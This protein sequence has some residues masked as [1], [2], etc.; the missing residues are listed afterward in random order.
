M[1]EWGRE[2][3][4]GWQE[5]RESIPPIDLTSLVPIFVSSFLLFVHS[6]RSPPASSSAPFVTLSRFTTLRG[7][8]FTLFFS[9][10]TRRRREPEGRYA[11]VRE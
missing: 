11:T 10:N 2:S 4:A 1:G 9:L 6:A 5:H 3:G 7:P 8:S